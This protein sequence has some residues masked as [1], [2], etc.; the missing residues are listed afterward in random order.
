M[1]FRSRVLAPSVRLNTLQPPAALASNGFSDN[2]GTQQNGIVK[3]AAM[4]GPFAA[5]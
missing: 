1:D 4:V 2:G 5:S 3:G